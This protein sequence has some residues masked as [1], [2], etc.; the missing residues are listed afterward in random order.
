MLLET[1]AAVSQG[2]VRAHSQPNRGTAVMLRKYP[3]G[4]LNMYAPLGLTWRH[5]MALNA[6]PLGFLTKMGRYGDL[7]FY[8]ILTLRAYVVNHPDLIRDVL[9][10]KAKSFRKWEH[11]MRAFR[12]GVGNGL[13]TSH[14]DEWRRQRRMVQK[15]LQMQRMGHY[16]QITVDHTRRMVE[17]WS[18]RQDVL[19]EHEM[20]LLGQDIM[21]KS[22]FDVQDV[23][24]AEE[25]SRAVRIAS[26]TF[27]R[28]NY[29]LFK[30][31]DWAPLQR[32]RQKRWALETLDRIVRKIIQQ[33]RRSRSHT[34]D[35]LSQLL[36]AEDDGR[37][38]TD[39]EVRDQAVTIFTAGYHTTAV[40]LAWVFYLLAK[41]RE[42]Q[43]RVQQEVDTVL[44][45]RAATLE[46]VSQLTYLEMVI[47]ETLRLYPP[48][49]AL[50]GRETIETVELGGYRID[51]GAYIGVFPWITQRDERFFPDPLRFNPERFAP[52]RAEQI[53]PFAYF[54]FGA[55]PHICVGKHFAKMEIPLIVATVLQRYRVELT[56]SQRPLRLDA[57]VSLRMKDD[58]AV[59]FCSRCQPA[60]VPATASP[61]VTHPGVWAAKGQG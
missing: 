29:L 16:A 21:A 58:I 30:L 7:S 10:T 11:Q 35:L 32:Q 43:A 59:S 54:P 42:V 6:N 36:L 50:F 53:S 26:D 18:E 33:R 51:K 34:E 52:S 28:E 2:G 46:D 24:E 60:G 49:Y 8:R 5:F 41:H 39:N 47:Q 3:P 4:P 23:G 13:L 44:N 14:G 40:A 45:G 25:L 12:Q 20:V 56:D 38:L 15:P 61:H 57:G 22:L 55:G 19:V 9:V 17:H 31:P 27:A 1:G 48:A 37:R